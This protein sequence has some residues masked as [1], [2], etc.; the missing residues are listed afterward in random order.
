MFYSLAFIITKIYPSLPWASTLF[1]FSGTSYAQLYFLQ[2]IALWVLMKGA[3]SPFLSILALSTAAIL[4][5]PYEPHFAL[6]QWIIALG[7]VLASCYAIYK[8][9][10]QAYPRSLPFITATFS[11]LLFIPQAHAYFFA[12][13]FTTY[14]V[15]IASICIFSFLLACYDNYR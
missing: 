11:L 4:L 13:S 9:V 14:L 3:R 10:L 8:L 5:T 15:T 1:F 12:G 2:T 6:R 7:I